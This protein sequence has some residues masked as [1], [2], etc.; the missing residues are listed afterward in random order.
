MTKLHYTQ[1]KNFAIDDLVQQFYDQPEAKQTAK[2][3]PLTQFQ[4]RAIKSLNLALS[5]DAPG[6]NVYLSGEVGAGKEALAQ[7]IA[8]SFAKDRPTPPDQM[9][10]YNFDDPKTP[11]LFLFE[12]GQANVFKQEM[13]AL[14]EELSV[15]LPKS[16]AHQTFEDNKTA[17]S[18]MYTQKRDEVIK[19]IS[20]EAKKYDFSVKTT[21]TGIYFMPIVD[22]V[23]IS[24][25]EYNNLED[26]QKDKI[27][28]RSNEMQE[29]VHHIM[30]RIREFDH[31][32]KSEIEELEFTELL[33]V[34]GR[35]FSPL[36]EKY[37][38]NEPI[39]TY[40][41][42][43]KEDVLD[44]LGAF[45]EP[46]ESGEEDLM[47]AMMPWHVKKDAE[48]P[49]QKYKVNVIVD[50][51]K[52]TG[53]PVIID[54]NPSY[55]TMVGEVEYENEY[56]NF[57]TD[58][59]KIVP[60]LLHKAH[61]GYLILRAKDLTV[62]TWES[63]LRT[64]KTDEVTIEPLKE[65][66]TLAVAG[67]KPQNLANIDVKIILL[68]DFHLYD[69]LTTYE[70]DFRQLFKMRG[71]FDY[72]M[73]LANDAVLSMLQHV[74]AFEQ[75]R[76]VQFAPSAL[77]EIITYSTRL[78]GRQDKLVS[79]LTIIDELLEEA[80][81]FAKLGNQHEITSNI[82]SQAITEKIQR[83]NLYEQKLTDYIDQD[84]IMLDTTGQK[85]GQINGL[86]VIDMDEYAFGKPT[87]I[88]ATSYAG[89]SGIINIEKEARLSGRIHD[90]GVHILSGYLGHMY[91][92]KHP[93][94]VSVRISFEQNYS[95]IDGDSASSTELYAIVSSL[96]GLP[97][98]QE[99]AV[100]GSMNQ[101]GEIQAI[102]GA[103]EKIEG[104]FDT[105][106][107][108]GLTGSQGVIIP[109][110]NVKDLVLKNEVIEAVE[111]DQFAIYAIEHVDQGIE[112]LMGVQANEVHAKVQ[113]R[114]DTYTHS[115]KQKDSDKDESKVSS[116]E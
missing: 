48:D 56:G 35:I 103:T 82:I 107:K 60:G 73:P 70:D 109:I 99:I 47:A 62:P 79:N 90:K 34:V 46:V 68:G 44:N 61:G 6:Y 16:L 100:T 4:H 17:I 67:I 76:R 12:A 33:F 22:G 110:A 114:L 26:D 52:L 59:M 55:Q 9:Y 1:L 38:D 106:K 84:I 54:Y 28:A 95:G 50:N 108:R 81:A 53:A 39:L 3:S 40:L 2:T 111:N 31:M 91:A 21:G 83:N 5:I 85:V 94:S 45:M 97:I 41:K 37:L 27:L 78:A 86:S 8:H 74:H 77:G 57:T 96:S 58:F 30:T 105:C 98:S 23:I 51:S 88:T 20:Q 102:G 92:Q 19:H 24:E 29:N 71:D 49:L 25:E 66:Q 116:G 113:Q 87:K 101:Y 42:H 32:A 69:I 18:K 11:V 104:F 63:I 15:E 36:L 14:V 64:L 13:E 7:E 10:A 112:L 65:F 115:E 43:V 80:T 89:K 93:L 72:E 75:Q